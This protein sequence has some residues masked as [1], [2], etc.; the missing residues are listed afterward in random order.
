MPRVKIVAINGSLRKRS[1]NGALIRA[2]SRVAPAGVEIVVYDKLEQIPPFNAD[3]DEEGLVPPEVVAQT[4]RMLIDAEAILI[5]S[6]EYAHGIPGALKNLLD[7]LVSTG[8]LVGKPVAL[9]NAAPAGGQHAQ[10]SL[11]ETLRTMNWNVVEA[12]SL[13]EPF[14]ER[15]IV[16]ELTGERPLSKL[17]LA[18]EALVAASPR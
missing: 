18:V 4:R 7:W 2:A 8:E 15:K 5:S 17:R 13:V 6:P 3:L 1:S 12:A 11:V 9:L 10:A 14:V 16:D